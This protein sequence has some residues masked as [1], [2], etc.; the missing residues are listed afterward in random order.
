MAN[1][2]PVQSICR[3]RVPASATKP[4]ATMS[5]VA[6]TAMPAHAT[7]RPSQTGRSDKAGA[8]EGLPAS[9]LLPSAALSVGES[10]AGAAADVA[11]VVG[12]AAGV[13]RWRSANATMVAIASAVTA[14]TD[15][16]AA[17]LAPMMLFTSVISPL[18]D[19]RMA[20]HQG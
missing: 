12:V 15:T 11:V 2:T 17:R 7:S 14:C 18:S 10:L 1:T 3:V 20:I 4:K 13:R 9:V 8:S 6:T 19:A 5:T 16:S